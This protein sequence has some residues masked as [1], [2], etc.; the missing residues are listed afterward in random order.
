MFVGL[1]EDKA[2]RQGRVLS[3]L[4][5]ESWWLNV[6][7]K[8]RQGSRVGRVVADRALAYRNGKR[9]RKTFYG[10]TQ[11]AGLRGTWLTS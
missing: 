4:K 2:A 9:V 11:A 7:G 1:R 8:A 6:H 5:G 10:K 3:K